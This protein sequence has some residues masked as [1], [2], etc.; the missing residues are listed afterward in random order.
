MSLAK[1]LLE[2]QIQ[3]VL[4]DGL[5]IQLLRAGVVE[6]RELGD[7]MDVTSLCGGREAMQEVMSSMNRCLSGLG[8]ESRGAG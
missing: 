7:V 6:L 3:F 8:R 1:F 2:Q 5:Q 4:A